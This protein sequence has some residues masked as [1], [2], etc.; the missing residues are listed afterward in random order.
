MSQTEEEQITQFKNWWKENGNSLIIGVLIAVAL[1]GGWRWWQYYKV[2]QKEQASLIYD[3]SLKGFMAGADNSAI[4]EQVS[5]L[6]KEYSGSGY[7]KYGALW[8]AKIAVEEK[9]LTEAADL[10]RALIASSKDQ[11]IRELA[12]TRLARVLLDLKQYDEALQILKQVSKDNFYQAYRFEL[13]GD[14]LLA[15]SKLLE[16]KESY[17]KA[18]SLMEDGYSTVFLQ[19]K[20]DNLTDTD[21]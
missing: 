21:S 17:L 12:I 14:I 6:T 11:Q 10:L 9:K 20:I 8:L 5:S 4:V 2:A 13:Q 3:A 18:K 1:T 16:A 19:Q 15:Q 7:A